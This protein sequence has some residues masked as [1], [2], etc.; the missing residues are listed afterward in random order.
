MLKHIIRLAPIASIAAGAIACGGSAPAPRGQ[1]EAACDTEAARQVAT[2]FGERLKD[3]SLLAPDTVVTREIRASYDALV[4]EELLRS[5]IG[6][7]SSAP[8]RQLSSPWP[9]RIEVRAVR[10]AGASMCVVEG[11]V[12]Y[13]TSAEAAGRGI[14]SRTPVTLHVR[15]DG[16][17]RISAY[18]AGSR[19]P[20]AGAAAGTPPS[21]SIV[22]GDSAA[23]AAPTDA[24]SEPTDVVRRY[25][26]AIAAK[27]YRRA[28]E[29]WGGGGAASGK[30]Y[31]QFAN[32]F[33]ETASVEARVG[34]PGRVEGAAGSRYVDVPVTIEATTTSGEHQ[35]FEGSYTL[36]RTVVEGSTPA[37]R[38]WHIYSAHILP[39]G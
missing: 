33:A 15:N 12:V 36:R 31:E 26:A 27:D 2:R 34:Q 1:T 38:R 13:V 39:A 14:A 19:A 9:D 6:D 24:A 18:D 7:P 5:W 16:E 22:A 30:P 11:D 4:T 37:Q 35:R 32:G 8:G 3:V 28:Y 29:M 10:P 25:Y 20:A 21:D 17:W 23:G